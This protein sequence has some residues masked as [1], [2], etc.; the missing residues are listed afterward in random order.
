M[1]STPQV[2]VL[3]REY[4][5]VAGMTPTELA[6]AAQQ[7]Y[8]DFD[9]VTPVE[10]FESSVGGPPATV[11]RFDADARLLA[12]GREVD[13]TSTPA[14]RSNSAT[15]TSSH[16]QSTCGRSAAGRRSSSD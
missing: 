8:A 15:S 3:G 9:G 13:A 2:R 10:R 12:V 16:W 5:P 7:R 6:E 4:D 11:T 14:G 1:F